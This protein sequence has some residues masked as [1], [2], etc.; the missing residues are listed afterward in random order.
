MYPNNGAIAAHVAVCSAASFFR[1]PVFS[2][3]FRF[4]P[5]G[6]FYYWHKLV[7]TPVLYRANVLSTREN[8][9]YDCAPRQASENLPRPGPHRLRYV[10]LSY[11]PVAC[12]TR[13]PNFPS[14]F[15]CAAGAS[16]RTPPIFRSRVPNFYCL[17]GPTPLVLKLAY[18]CRASSHTW[19]RLPVCG[20]V[21]VL[22]AFSAPCSGRFRAFLQLRSPPICHLALVNLGANR[23]SAERRCSACLHHLD[24]AGFM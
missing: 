15:A 5:F 6:A 18:F 16:F 23:R 3:R 7:H 1:L 12:V 17:R 8:F 20:R 24:L 19:P 9:I 4:A 10:P 13:S 2:G 21:S 22:A 14:F 11:A